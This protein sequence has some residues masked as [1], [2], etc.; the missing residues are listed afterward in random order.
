MVPRTQRSRTLPITAGGVLLASIITCANASDFSHFTPLPES[1][2]P[3]I[4]EGL[5]ITFGNP[6]FMQRSIVRRNTQLDDQKPNSGNFD[7]NTVNETGKDK[8]RY[9]FTVFETATSG[10]Q[11]HDLETGETDTV[12]QVPPGEIAARFDPVT[13]TP[14][15]TLITGEENWGCANSVCGRLF[16]LR[17]PVAA[18]AIFEPVDAS[19]ND[20]ADL[21][22]RNAVPRSSH[23]G[24]QFDMSGNM[25]FVDELNGGSIYKYVPAARMHRVLSARADYF[26]AGQTFVLRV[27]DGNTPNASG[28]YAWVPI[29]DAEGD[30]LPGTVVVAAR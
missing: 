4:Y 26:A 7:M 25:Y 29:T 2:G 14:W 9:L 17:N 24:L 21:V 23:E 12:W 16:E 13:W 1:A 3:N 30:A 19:S 22:H 6:D 28:A 20:G 11:R 8:G 10:V 5:P 15:G 27:G 18:P